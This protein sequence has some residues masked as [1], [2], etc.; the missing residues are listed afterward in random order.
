LMPMHVR[1]L[2]CGN[3]RH[4]VMDAYAELM[5]VKQ[6]PNNLRYH[7]ISKYFLNLK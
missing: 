6:Y 4:G 7:K 3:V 5:T 2:R 1:D